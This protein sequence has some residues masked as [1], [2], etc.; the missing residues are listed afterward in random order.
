MF[1][2]YDDGDTFEVKG[3]FSLF[4]ETMIPQIKV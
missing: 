4:K 3:T 1:E 2:P